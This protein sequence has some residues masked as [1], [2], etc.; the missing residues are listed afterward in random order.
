MELAGVEQ[1]D[2]PTGQIGIA[3]RGCMVDVALLARWGTG[4]D[5]NPSTCSGGNVDQ[6]PCGR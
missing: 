1:P 4:L 3:L 6:I 2:D 5:G